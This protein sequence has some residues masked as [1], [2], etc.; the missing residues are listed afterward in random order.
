MMTIETVDPICS[1]AHIGDTE[2]TRQPLNLRH[3]V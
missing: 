1:R 2:C 3:K